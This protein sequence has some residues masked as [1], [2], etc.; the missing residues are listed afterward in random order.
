MGEILGLGTT[1]YPRLRMP[2]GQM[3]GPLKGNL[4]GTHLKPEMR[5]PKNWPAPMQA[6]W[7]NDEG[8][9]TG[10]KARAHQVEQFRKLK[11]DLDAFRPDFILIWSKDQAESL[12]KIPSP[13]YFIHAYPTAQAKVYQG[14]GGRGSGTTLF[15][16][17]VEKVFTIKGHPEG[18]KTLVKGLQEAGFDPTWTQEPPTATP[19]GIAHTFGGVLTHLDWDKREFATPYVFVSVD[20]FGPRQ[21]GADGCSPIKPNDPRPISPQRAFEMGRQTARIL[22][23]SPYRVALVSGV[24]WSHANNTSWDRSWVHPDI[25]GD[26]KRYEQLTSNQFAKWNDMTY[27]EMEEHGQW[28]LL[29]WLPLMGAMTELGAKLKWSDFTGHYI[30]NSVWVNCAF[31]PA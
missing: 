26:K 20:P 7:G 28:E 12:G 9:E 14:P 31:N 27:D 21:R 18:A 8:L 19:A 3:N 13:P 22:K 5:D 23:R 29:C 30:F 17:E 16:D 2:D 10:K 1:D 24:G 4:G 6:E 25:E 11:A 15:G